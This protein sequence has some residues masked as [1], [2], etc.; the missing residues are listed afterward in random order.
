MDDVMVTDY[1]NYSASVLAE[2]FGKS[3][4][5]V[6]NRAWLLGITGGK[7]RGSLKYTQHECDV[8]LAEY[9]HKTPTQIAQERGMSKSQV[10]WIIKRAMGAR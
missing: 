6:R 8:I 4:S 1:P 2:R 5:A 7:P 3:V 10:D 9:V